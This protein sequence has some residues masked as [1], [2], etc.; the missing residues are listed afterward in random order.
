MDVPSLGL[1]APRHI[2]VPRYPL[3]PNFIAI[4]AKEVPIL[5]IA[6]ILA[7]CFLGKVLI[8]GTLLGLLTCRAW[9]VLAPMR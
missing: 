5:R 1:A 9:R 4:L 8:E 7:A 2:C 3:R 6:L